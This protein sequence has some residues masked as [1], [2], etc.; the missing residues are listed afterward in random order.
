MA[1]LRETLHRRLVVISEAKLS[2]CLSVFQVIGW[3][4]RFHAGLTL[5]IQFALKGKYSFRALLQAD[6]V[7]R[8]HCFLHL[9]AQALPHDVEKHLRVLHRIQVRRPTLLAVAKQLLRQRVILCVGI[10]ERGVFRHTVFVL[11]AHNFTRYVV[12]VWRPERPVLCDVGNSGHLLS[13]V[14]HYCILA[15]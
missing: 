4:A 14:D 13:G 15:S 9:F 8:S 6:V 11:R 10:V 2:D 5:A 3:L 12:T 1:R 7:V